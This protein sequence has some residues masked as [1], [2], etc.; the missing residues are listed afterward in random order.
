MYLDVGA[1]ETEELKESSQTSGLSHL[2]GSGPLSE[3]VKAW[4]GT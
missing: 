2:V 1:R 4:R 3:M